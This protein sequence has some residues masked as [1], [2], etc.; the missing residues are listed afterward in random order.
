MGRYKTIRRHVCITIS[1]YHREKRPNPS[2][3][4]TSRQW[5]QNSVLS[6]E[7][8]FSHWNL[9]M[10]KGQCALSC[11]VYSGL[12]WRLFVLL[13]RV[14]R[15]LYKLRGFMSRLPLFRGPDARGSNSFKKHFSRLADHFL[16]GCLSG[17]LCCWNRHISV[18]REI[19]PGSSSG[20][21]ESEPEN[22]TFESCKFESPTYQQKWPRFASKTN[23]VLV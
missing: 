5:A 12:S 21:L 22:S 16:M 8:R 7:H 11:F 6:G 14:S 2:E 10:W 1:I 13:S 17:N 4:P 20:G 9:G 18:H 15:A 23:A 3:T 19:N